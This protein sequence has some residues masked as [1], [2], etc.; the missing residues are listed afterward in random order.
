MGSTTGRD[1]IRWDGQSCQVRPTG[2]RK[3]QTL[4]QNKTRCLHGHISSPQPTN[5]MCMYLALSGNGPDGNHREA[6]HARDG[7]NDPEQRHEGCHGIHDRSLLAVLA[8][9]PE[10]VKRV[11][12]VRDEQ[13]HHAASS[14]I[15]VIMQYKWVGQNNITAIGEPV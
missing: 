12:E 1:E 14:A 5:N 9:F 6:G 7:A 2:S 4:V 8:H 10:P 15:L 3:K 11:A 13:W